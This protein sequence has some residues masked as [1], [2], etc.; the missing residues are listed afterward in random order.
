MPLFKKKL[1]YPSDTDIISIPSYFQT[2]NAHPAYVKEIVLDHVKIVYF[3][4]KYCYCFLVD[5][6]FYCNYIMYIS[7]GSKFLSFLPRYLIFCYIDGILT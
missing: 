6:S 7:Q 4:Y 2:R 1:L 3:T 5:T